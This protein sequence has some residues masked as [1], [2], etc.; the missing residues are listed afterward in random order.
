MIGRRPLARLALLLAAASS[1]ACD[2]GGGHPPFAPDRLPP[3]SAED[4]ASV[5][6]DDARVEAEERGTPV[7]A[8]RG[9]KGKGRSAPAGR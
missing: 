3:L 7:L 2:G 4:L 5:H 9:R 8:G 1:T 6:A